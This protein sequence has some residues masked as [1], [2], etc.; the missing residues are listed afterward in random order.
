MRPVHA[1]FLLPFLAPILVYST[2]VPIGAG[3]PLLQVAAHDDPRG[4]WEWTELGPLQNGT[5]HSL[6]V[7]VDL[8]GNNTPDQDQPNTFVTI[9][10]ATV[11]PAFSGSA[12]HFRIRTGNTFR[13]KTGH[14]GL[15]SG[16]A[17][18]NIHFDPPIVLEPNK[19]LVVDFQHGLGGTSPLFLRLSGRVIQ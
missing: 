17:W 1:L 5:G 8:D 16:E 13:W 6:T 2:N 14:Q 11:Y 15:A 9:E 10:Q 19:P 7:V 4:I 3:G 18:R 12:Y